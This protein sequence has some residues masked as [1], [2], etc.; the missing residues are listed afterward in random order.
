MT[1]ELIIER[2]QP[3]CGG[4]SPYKCEFRTVST[5][6][7]VAYVMQ[8]EPECELEV[9]EENGSIVVE[10]DRNGRRIK[11]EFTEE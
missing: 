2:Q 9:S 4:N 7:P 11:Y 8:L 3:T 6:D 1:Y 10:G 5:D